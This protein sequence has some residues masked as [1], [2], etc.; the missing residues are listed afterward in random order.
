[1]VLLRRVLGDVLRMR[2][3][4]Q[5][6][7]LRDVSTDAKV[8][9]GYLSEIERGQ[10]E[11]SSELLAAICE[12]LNIQ[13]SEV[14]RDVTSTVV[15]AEEVDGVQ[16]ATA[17]KAKLD[18]AVI[19]KAVIDKAVIDKAVIEKATL[20]KAKLDKAKLDKAKLDKAKL[21]KVLDRAALDSTA[22]DPS[23]L[24][25]VSLDGTTL[26]PATNRQ[27]RAADRRG[28]VVCAA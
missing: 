14:L 11:A 1:M 27:R 9:L 19:D 3:L 26:D 13:L 22:L 23:A 2:R 8:S 21:D 6:R 7:T 20:D 18:K 17:D 5:R 28:D 16:P 25:K 10:K 15:L 24:E 12:A 4:T